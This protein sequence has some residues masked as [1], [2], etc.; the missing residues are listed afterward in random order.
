MSELRAN[1]GCFVNYPT[2]STP[3][4]SSSN[5]SSVRL[6][7]TGYYRAMADIRVIHQK[8]TRLVECSTLKTLCETAGCHRTD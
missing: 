4:M 6:V 1:G 8:K 3:R 5:P 7:D 2:L